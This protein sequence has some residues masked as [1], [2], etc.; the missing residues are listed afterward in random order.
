MNSLIQR[1]YYHFYMSKCRSDTIINPGYTFTTQIQQ[2]QNKL[3]A[4]ITN[5]PQN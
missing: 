2:A 3:K 1:V 4:Y 5:L